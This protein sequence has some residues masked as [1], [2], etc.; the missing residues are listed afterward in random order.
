MPGRPMGGFYVLPEGEVT[1][2][3][4]RSYEYAMTL[5]PKKTKAKRWAPSISAVTP[6]ETKRYLS[7]MMSSSMV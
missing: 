3:V 7:T 2:W 6:S 1:D 4:R 5:P